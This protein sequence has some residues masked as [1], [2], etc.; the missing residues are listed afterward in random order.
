MN[1]WDTSAL[2]ALSMD[3]PRRQAA[4]CVLESDDQTVVWWGSAIE[5]VAA[6]SR[7]EWDGSLKTDEVSEHLSR[8]NAPSQV[9]YEVQPKPAD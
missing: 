7:R 5:Y 1:L 8:L 3:E 9:W 6:V 2:G 4:L